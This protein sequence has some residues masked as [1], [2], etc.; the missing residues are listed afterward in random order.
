M[1][2]YSEIK[3]HAQQ[4]ADLLRAMSNP[5]RLMILCLL[6]QGELSVTQINHHLP[7]PQ[8]SL[9]QHLAALRKEG[10]VQTRRDA[11]TIYYSLNS[12]E[13]KAMIATLHQLYCSNNT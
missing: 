6:Q 8:S 9:S 7:M 12:H 4:A 3:Q 11:Q 10:Y 13:V 2:D 5:H 1:Q